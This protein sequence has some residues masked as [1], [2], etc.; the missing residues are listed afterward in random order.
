MLTKSLSPSC[1]WQPSGLFQSF[2]L[3]LCVYEFS[4]P[5]YPLDYS[6]A[7]Q[8]SAK[9][10]MNKNLIYFIIFVLFIHS[11]AYDALQGKTTVY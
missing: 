3:L 4:F 2:F 5:I 11:S 8:V 9:K 10:D 1:V 7:L 6:S